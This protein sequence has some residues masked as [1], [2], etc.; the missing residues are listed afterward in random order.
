MFPPLV[1]STWRD[2]SVV[3]IVVDVV[4]LLMLL[5]VVQL[6]ECL[7]LIGLPELLLQIHCSSHLHTWRQ[8]LVATKRPLILLLLLLLLLLI[9]HRD[10]S[11]SIDDGRCICRHSGC[12]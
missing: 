5:P 4:L 9:A 10:S 11:S 7:F 3:V 12:R 1:S 2:P 6:L 8:L